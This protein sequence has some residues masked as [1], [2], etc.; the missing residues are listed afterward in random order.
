MKLHLL[1]LA[2]LALPFSAQAAAPTLPPE[3]QTGLR[4][5]ALFSIVAGE[6]ARQGATDW[7]PLTQRGR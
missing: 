4:C 1:P 5:A 3:L 2:L 6:Q 7:P